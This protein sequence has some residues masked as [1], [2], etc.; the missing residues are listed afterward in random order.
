MGNS[1]ERRMAIWHTLC[2]HRQVT[3]AYLSSKYG[4]SPRTIRYDVE[5]LSRTHPLETR[6]GKNGG[7]KLA[8]WYQP[9]NLLLTTA[10]M[11]LL[12]NLSYRLEGDEAAMLSDII[13]I[14][15]GAMDK[16]ISYIRKEN[17]P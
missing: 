9:S 10:Q 2:A 6:A 11:D 5:A 4:V 16:H 13:V 14:L 17:L 15:S 12:L 3:I 1:R 7:V 8:D